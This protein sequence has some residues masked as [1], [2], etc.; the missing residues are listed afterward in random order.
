MAMNFF[1]TLSKKGN[2]D[3]NDIELYKELYK[4]VRL[5]SAKALSGA[6]H[7]E[8]MADFYRCITH[9]GKIEINFL[10]DKFTEA[11][12][13]RILYS[14]FIVDGAYYGISDAHKEGEAISFS[15]EYYD[16][17]KYKQLIDIIGG[18]DYVPEVEF[19]RNAILPTIKENI[20]YLVNQLGDEK[21]IINSAQGYVYNKLGVVKDLN[22]RI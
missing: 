6:S 9:D 5:D 21:N 11:G 19:E 18:S 17:D 1:N 12:D 16:K 8:E 10:L 22:E 4:N 15:F 3:Q 7:L 20:R 13:Y 14:Y 2:V